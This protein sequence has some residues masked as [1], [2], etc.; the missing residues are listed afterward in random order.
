MTRSYHGKK[1]QSSV[2]SLRKS[3]AAGREIR[4]GIELYQE[5]LQLLALTISQVLLYTL[6]AEGEEVQKRL[7]KASPGIY[8]EG[9]GYLCFEICITFI[10]EKCPLA[11]VRECYQKI[12]EL[13]PWGLSLFPSPYEGEKAFILSMQDVRSRRWNI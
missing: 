2:R 7:G 6:R 9:K 8:R 11:L 3:R 13:L 1:G 4:E 5:S 12:R 10:V